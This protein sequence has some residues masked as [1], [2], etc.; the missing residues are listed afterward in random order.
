MS[1]ESGRYGGVYTPKPFKPKQYSVEVLASQ[2]RASLEDQERVR[3]ECREAGRCYTAPP[4]YHPEGTPRFSSWSEYKGVVLKKDQSCQFCEV[5]S[6]PYGN[7]FSKAFNKGLWQL[8]EIMSAIDKWLENNERE[9]T[10]RAKPKREY[11][12]VESHFK[13]YK[14]GEYK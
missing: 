13:K 3:Q 14:L 7:N 12:S 1:W 9:Q 10:E 4:H 11:R 8:R 6:H 5:Y 2:E